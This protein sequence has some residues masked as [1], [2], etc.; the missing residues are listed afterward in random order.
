MKPIKASITNIQ[1][2]EL[3]LTFTSSQWGEQ[4]LLYRRK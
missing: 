2:H 1:L 3:L 4:C